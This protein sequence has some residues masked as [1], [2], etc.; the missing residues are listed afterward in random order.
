[1]LFHYHRNLCRIANISNID[2]LRPGTITPK[3]RV[4]LAKKR[5]QIDDFAVPLEFAVHFFPKHFSVG[6]L[7]WD[8]NLC[9][10]LLAGT[11]PN[12]K[13]NK[14]ANMC[15][16]VGIY[17]LGSLMHTYACINVLYIHS[18]VHLLILHVFLYLLLLLWFLASIIIDN[19]YIY[20][21]IQT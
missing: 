1:M 3:G 6:I 4:I 14:L 15:E 7:G 21:Y 18:F 19:I 10:T 9:L 12:R 13:P 16:N 20:L 5:I 2:E 17:M 8:P 11:M